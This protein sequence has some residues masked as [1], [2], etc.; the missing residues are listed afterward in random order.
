MCQPIINTSHLCRNLSVWLT[1]RRDKASLSAPRSAGASGGPWEGGNR[2]ALLRLAV[3]GRQGE[4]PGA[5]MPRS[6]ALAAFSGNSQ[7]SRSASGKER[8]PG[9]PAGLGPAAP[10]EEKRPPLL[11]AR[12]GSSLSITPS[13]RGLIRASGKQSRVYHA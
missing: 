1:Q 9:L 10:P 13:P 2:E 3:R 6:P 8:E 4:L 7:G 5:G 12:P 11:P